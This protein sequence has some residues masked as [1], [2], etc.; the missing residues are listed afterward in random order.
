LLALAQPASGADSPPPLRAVSFNVLHGGFGFRGD[1]Q[2]LDSTA[3]TS[4]VKRLLA[5]EGLVDTFRTAN[6]HAPGFTVWQPARAESSSCSTAGGLRARRPGRRRASPCPREPRHP[7]PARPR[8]WWEGAVGP[9]T[10]A[11]AALR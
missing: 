7:R 3:D 5:D 2:H 9:S 1:G 10:A 8:S 6:P 11:A 4:G